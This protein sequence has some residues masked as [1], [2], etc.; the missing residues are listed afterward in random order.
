MTSE[1]AVAL[2][3]GC[4]DVDIAVLD[5]HTSQAPRND[6]TP[7]TSMSPAGVGV[8]PHDWK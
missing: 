5:R 1:Q 8:N 4:Q 2:G 7:D 3:A 6:W